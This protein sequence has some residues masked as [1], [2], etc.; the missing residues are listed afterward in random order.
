MT[1][2]DLDKLEKIVYSSIADVIPARVT[3]IKLTNIIMMKVK[4]EFNE[5]TPD[6]EGDQ[7][8]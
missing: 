2:E 3:I 5:S 7:H 1:S 8:L 6:A 4:A